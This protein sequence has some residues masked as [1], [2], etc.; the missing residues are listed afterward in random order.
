MRFLKNDRILIV[1]SVSFFQ[2]MRRQTPHIRIIELET[3]YDLLSPKHIALIRRLLAL[4]PRT[5]GIAGE[6][7]GI[8]GVPHDLVRIGKQYIPETTMLRSSETHFLPKRI[9]CAYR[10]MNN[11]MFR[12]I[13]QKVFIE[14]GYRSPG[15]QLIIFLEYLVADEFDIRRTLKRVTLPGYSEH[16]APDRQAID[17]QAI[18]SDEPGTKKTGF[19]YT[20]EYSWLLLHA[21]KYGFRLSYPRGNKQGIM[22]EPWHWHFEDEH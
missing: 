11:A 15:Y 6:Y 10:R 21:D 22:F 1:E 19:E 8:T 16:G 9:L 13:E 7:Y 18:V 3:I 20:K 17:F 12:D 2:V 5:Y 4:H 14:S